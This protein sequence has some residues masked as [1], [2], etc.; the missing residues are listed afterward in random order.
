GQLEPSRVDVVQ[1]EGQL[2]QVV[3]GQQVAQQLAGELRRAGADEAHGGH[4][5]SMARGWEPK[6]D[7]SRMVTASR[8]VSARTA[9]MSS[10]RPTAGAP[11]ACSSSATRT[12]TWC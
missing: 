2:A 4:R 1:D 12:R 11:H 7:R 10:C 3:E 9:M 5:A 6:Q 8:Q